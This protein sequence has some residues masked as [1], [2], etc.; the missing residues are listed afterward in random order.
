[1]RSFIPGIPSLADE[2]RRDLVLGGLC[3]F[4]C[5][6][7]PGF[8]LAQSASQRLP[9]APLEGEELP[10]ATKHLCEVFVQRMTHLG[11]HHWSGGAHLVCSGG[12]GSFLVLRLPVAQAG[13]YRLALYAT[14]SPDIGIIE[15]SHQGKRLGQPIDCYADHAEPSGRIPLGTLFLRPSECLLRFE[16]VGK[17]RSSSNYRF[18]I[19]CLDLVLAKETASAEDNKNSGKSFQ[20]IRLHAIQVCDDNGERSADISPLQVKAWVDQANRVFAQAGLHFVF[21]PRRDGPDWTVLKNWLVNDLSGTDQGDWQRA[22]DEGNKAAARF[23]KKMVVF[24]RH[25]PGATPTGGG[26]S[27]TDCNFVAMPGFHQTWVG[28]DQNINALAREVGHY[29]GLSNTFAKEFMTV[30]DAERYF[31]EHKRD[32]AIFDGDGLG[33]TPPDPFVRA[34]QV[35]RKAIKLTLDGVT[36]PLPRDNLMSCYLDSNKKLSRLQIQRIQKVLGTHPHRKLL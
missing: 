25:G 9:L 6:G 1:M 14:R 7:L 26:F 24:F 29:L 32:P 33:D 2:L 34:F 16:V 5:A 31:K 21:D 4:L 8:G 30:P 23:P 13:S 35:D 3:L 10:I 20:E 17:N 15:V 28:D 22:K 11:E 27:S 18:A 19:D 36:F 12:K